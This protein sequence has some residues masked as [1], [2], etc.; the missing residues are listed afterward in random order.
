[1]DSTPLAGCV[2]VSSAT[3]KKQITKFEKAEHVNRQLLYDL[4]S[5]I[6]EYLLV[7]PSNT[8]TSCET[9]ATTT[10]TSTTAET[11]FRANE[12]HA[13]ADNNRL[14]PNVES[15]LLHIHDRL[16]QIFL[17]GLRIVKPDVSSKHFGN[18]NVALHHLICIRA[19]Q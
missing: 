3:A 12:A 19:L 2:A 17:N 7:L 16:E 11:G 1:M 15:L 6:Y 13:S 9:A 4:M 10:T 8:K 14:M 5:S 18:F